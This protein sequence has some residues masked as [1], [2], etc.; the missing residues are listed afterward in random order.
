MEKF[1]K[2]L[3]GLKDKS[4]IPLLLENGYTP[5]TI[6]AEIIETF[7]PYFKNHSNLEKYAISCLVSDWI[8]FLRI[9]IKH[10][11]IE[12]NIKTVLDAYSLP[13]VRLGR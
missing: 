13:S 1:Q 9:S 3:E 7:K 5:S 10:T 6:K 12:N 11:G 2:I 8:N 4:P